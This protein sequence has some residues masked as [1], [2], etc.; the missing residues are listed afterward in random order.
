M[1][2][3][4]YLHQIQKISEWHFYRSSCHK[5]G[6]QGSVPLNP[7]STAV[8]VVVLGAPMSRFLVGMSK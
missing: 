8:T 2:S 4:S 6:P 1:T 3:F 5:T 7:L